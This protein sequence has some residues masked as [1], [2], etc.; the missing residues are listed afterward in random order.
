MFFLLS[1]TPTRVVSGRSRPMR[2]GFSTG[3]RRH[4][5]SDGPHS[6]LGQRACA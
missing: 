6:L 5:S 2:V 3:T 1:A 4:R